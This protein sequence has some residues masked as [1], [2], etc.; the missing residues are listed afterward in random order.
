MKNDGK[1]IG[2][3]LPEKP[4]KVGQFYQRIAV[5]KMMAIDWS[6]ESKNGILIPNVPFT[7]DGVD[8]NC[9]C[10][11]CLYLK[12]SR[13]TSERCWYRKIVNDKWHVSDPRMMGS[14]EHNMGRVAHNAFVFSWLIEQ[15][16]RLNEIADNSEIN[17][18]NAWLLN[19][20]KIEVSR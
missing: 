17:K 6:W 3:D 18:E 7:N 14:T 4:T 20:K 2:R 9:N 15:I 1:G 19:W 11:A 10:P 16:V 5:K 8:T 12:S 13:C